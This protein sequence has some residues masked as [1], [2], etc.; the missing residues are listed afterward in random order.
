MRFHEGQVRSMGNMAAGVRAIR[1]KDSSDGTK[2]VVVSM[3]IVQPEDELLVITAKGLG[4]RT[5][6]GRGSS[7]DLPNA[8][9]V[10]EGVDEA[11]ADNAEMADVE[12]PESAE[13]EERSAFR[14]RLTNRGTQG[15]ISIK[16]REG[17]HVVAALQV[18][19]DTRQDILLLSEKGQAVRTHINQIRLCGRASY[20]V[21]VMSMSK[22][23][24][25]VVNVSIVDELSEDDAAANAARAESEEQAAS[26]AA[27]FEA[28]QAQEQTALE[29][30][31]DEQVSLDN[32]APIDNA[33]D[34][35]EG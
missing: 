1:L 18:E 7:D 5:P 28:R 19:P 33:E 30:R 9:V 31:G 14:Y 35:N 11:A 16:L 20:G 27:D 6:I 13:A 3:T 25:R 17:D 22:E 4:K 32:G 2:D 23:N 34:K 29:N 15:C 8:P 26:D 10:A 12:L 24:D 21:K